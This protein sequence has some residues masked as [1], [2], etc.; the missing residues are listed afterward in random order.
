MG[1]AKALQLICNDQTSTDNIDFEKFSPH[2][3]DTAVDIQGFISFFDPL[4]VAL[5][6]SREAETWAE[7]VCNAP[8]DTKYAMSSYRKQCCANMGIVDI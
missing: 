1:A 7:E 6:G 4:V 5:S 2:A 3:I 8:I